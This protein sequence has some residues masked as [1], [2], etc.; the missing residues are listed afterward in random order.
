MALKL[1]RSWVGRLRAT[2]KDA[3][4]DLHSLLA[5]NTK[6][7]ISEFLTPTQVTDINNVLSDLENLLLQKRLK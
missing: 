1:V 6:H 2:I 4:G 3:I 7:P 5:Y